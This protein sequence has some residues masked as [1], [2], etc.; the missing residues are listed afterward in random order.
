MPQYSMAW[1]KQAREKYK[2]PEAWWA[3][4]RRKYY[5]ENREYTL[6]VNR[7]NR[8]KRLT[9][10]RA[11]KDKPCA[12]CGHKFPH[13][14]MEF[15][16]VRG[17]KK[18]CVSQING[19]MK[20]IREEIAKCEVVCANCHRIRTW[21]RKHPDRLLSLSSTSANSRRLNVS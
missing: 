13:P 2:Q 16:H 12:D 11:A 5:L 3:A 15:D 7:A 18:F 10:M 6:A 9:A 21:N 20:R 1:T 17:V 14:C 19:S 8:E 4:Y